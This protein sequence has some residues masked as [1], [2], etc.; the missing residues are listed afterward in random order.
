MF[1]LTPTLTRPQQ[2]LVL[3]AWA[4]SVSW[5]RL[6]ATHLVIAALS[7]YY[8]IRRP[9]PLCICLEHIGDNGPC[10]VHGPGQELGGSHA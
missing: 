6:L 10:P 4:R 8:R 5:P 9:K 7:R 1:P 2:K 3:A